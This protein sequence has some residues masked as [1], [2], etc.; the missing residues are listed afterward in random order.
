MKKLIALLT[1]VILFCESNAQSITTTN[2][3]SMNLPITGGRNWTISGTT[4]SANILN[5][6]TNYSDYLYFYGFNFS[7]LPTNAVINTFTVTITRGAQNTVVDSSVRLY[8]AGAPYYAANTNAAAIPTTWPVTPQAYTYTFMGGALSNITA[9]QMKAA[10]FGVLISTR[11]VASN[12]IQANV[13]TSATISMTYTVVLPLILTDFTAVKNADNQVDI[14]FSTSSEEN[15]DKIY[16]E[17]SADGKNFVKIFSVT[18]RGAKNVFTKYAM[19]DKAPLAGSNYYR[20]SEVDKNGRWYY[21]TTKIVNVNQK[22]A[23]YNAYYNGGQVVAN[24]SSIPG[25]YEVS[26]VDMTGIT[27]SRKTVTLNNG[28]GQVTLDAPARTG[29]Y[30]ALIKSEGLSQALRVAV[31]R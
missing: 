17:R 18:P 10:D 28:A 23:S 5:N 20:I 16:I 3:Q 8:V 19:T 2:T 30:I 31:T 13:S 29:I 25:Q 21:Y 22:G 27:I 1:A 26:L 24:I 12:L 14:R 4:A 7:S 11:K 6:G 15:V 9:A